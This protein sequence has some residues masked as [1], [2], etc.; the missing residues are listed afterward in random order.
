MEELEQWGLPIII[1]SAIALL[2]LL[3]VGVLLYRRLFGHPE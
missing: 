3:G 2:L 1:F